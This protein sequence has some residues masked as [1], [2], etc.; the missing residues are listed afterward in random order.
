MAALVLQVSPGGGFG[1]V[2]DQGYGV[3]YMIPGDNK[4][5]FHISSKRSSAGTDS[6]R[7]ARCLFASLRDMY[8]LVTGTK[9]IA[10]QT[11]ADHA[12]ASTASASV[13]VDAALAHK[14]SQ[15]RN[16]PRTNHAQTQVS[17]SF[18]DDDDDGAHDTNDTMDNGSVPT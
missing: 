10:C 11:D 12:H 16:P 9:G 5:F 13:A 8:D 6:Q 18:D 3:S 7:L 4:I 2:S 15:T 17:R 14:S 1:P